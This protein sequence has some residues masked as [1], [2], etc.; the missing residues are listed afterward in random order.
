MGGRVGRGIWRFRR[1]SGA[2]RAVGVGRGWERW[3][4]GVGMEF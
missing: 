2:R 3:R 4:G 1:H